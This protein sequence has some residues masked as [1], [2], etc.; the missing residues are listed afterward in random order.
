MR[1]YLDLLQGIL[2]HGHEKQDRTATGTLSVFGH[3]MRF[4]LSGGFPLVTTKKL[5]FKS[6]VHELLWFC[7]L[8]TSPSPRD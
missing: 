4:D 7:L 3:Q 6:V 2:D 8:Y 5:H 1:Q